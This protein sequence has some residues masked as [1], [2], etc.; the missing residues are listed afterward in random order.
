MPV[1]LLERLDWIQRNFVGGTYSEKL[2]LIK[3]NEVVKAKSSGGLGLGSLFLSMERMS[4]VGFLESP[5]VQDVRMFRYYP[6][7]HL[8][9]EKVHHL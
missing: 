4:E 5:Q 2:H 1:N 9:G 8:E 3:W 7:V 6:S